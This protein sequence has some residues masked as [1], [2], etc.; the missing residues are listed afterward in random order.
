MVHRAKRT[1]PY[2]LLGDNTLV[3]SDVLCLAPGRDGQLRLTCRWG[4]QGVCVEGGGLS[5]WWQRRS[6]GAPGWVPAALAG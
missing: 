3:L 6:G 5:L 4:V 1:V 2:P